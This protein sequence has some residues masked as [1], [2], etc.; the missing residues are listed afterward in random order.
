VENGC[1]R[2]RGAFGALFV[3]AVRK[4]DEVRMERDLGA[5]KRR[6]EGPDRRKR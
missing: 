1:R 3:E 4:M 5:L 6:V 2:V